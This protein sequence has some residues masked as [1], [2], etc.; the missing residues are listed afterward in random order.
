MRS[1][2]FSKLPKHLEVH[3]TP[4]T[5]VL[6]SQKTLGMLVSTRNTEV[7]FFKGFLCNKL[8]QKPPPKGG[9]RHLVESVG[10]S[11]HAFQRKNN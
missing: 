8:R 1:G 7:Y 5:A 6:A 4:S 3:L 11:C 2:V 10:C 9:E